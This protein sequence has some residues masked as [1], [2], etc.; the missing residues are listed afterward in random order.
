MGLNF[1]FQWMMIHIKLVNTTIFWKNALENK[2]KT[3]NI[4][5]FSLYLFEAL[6]FVHSSEILT[7]LCNRDCLVLLFCYNNGLGCTF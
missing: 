4:T 5:I 3:S 2:S 7:K 1:F 6:G